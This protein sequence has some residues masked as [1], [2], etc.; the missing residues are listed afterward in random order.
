[1][2]ESIANFPV[3]CLYYVNSE[4]FFFFPDVLVSLSLGNYNKTFQAEVLCLPMLLCLI[5]GVTLRLGTCPH[6]M[7]EKGEASAVQLWD[8]GPD[9]WHFAFTES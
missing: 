8:R 3:F 7:E 6:F 2:A 4:H 9:S 5:L 1:M